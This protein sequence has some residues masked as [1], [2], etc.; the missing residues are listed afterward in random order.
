MATYVKINNTQYPA[1]IYGTARDEN[2]NNRESKSI[3][4][5]MPY[6]EALNIFVDDVDWFIIQERE[7]NV[8]SLNIETK[9][10]VNSLEIKQEIYDN[11]EYSIAGDITNH[12]NGTVTIK[13]GKPTA[14]E[15]LKMLEEVF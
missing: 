7:E 2:W 11:S 10:F 3:V 13:M 6:D 15:I 4:V 5:E 12:R 14:E 1:I 8:Q 9:E